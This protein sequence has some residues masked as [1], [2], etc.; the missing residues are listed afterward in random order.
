MLY[1]YHHVLNLYHCAPKLQQ[2]LYKYLHLNLTCMKNFRYN[3]PVAQMAQLLLFL[4]VQYLSK[5]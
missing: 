3:I 1:R 2:P 4:N 5:Y